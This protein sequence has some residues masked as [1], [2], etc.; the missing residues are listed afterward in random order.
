MSSSLPEQ[1]ISAV[2]LAPKI[3]EAGNCHFVKFEAL[4]D[5][6]QPSKSIE[7]DE[8]LYISIQS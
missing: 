4:S 8:L 7:F 2:E 5:K 1:Y 3:N 6:Y